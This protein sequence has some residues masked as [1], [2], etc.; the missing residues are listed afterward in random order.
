MSD[1]TAFVDENSGSTYY[2]NAV[3]G[4]TSWEPP[5]GYYDENAAA[6]AVVESPVEEASYPEEEVGYT[7]DPVP[8]PSSPHDSNADE[9]GWLKYTDEA[10]GRPYFYNTLTRQTTWTEPIAFTGE[11]K[12]RQ[13]VEAP[14]SEE[15]E[16]EAIAAVAAANQSEYERHLD[17]NTQT[18]YYL[19]L[20]TGNTQWE[21]PECFK[22][23]QRGHTRTQ[24]SP[25]RHGFTESA[26]YETNLGSVEENTE[27][28]Q[29]TSG[30]GP[31]FLSPTAARVKGGPRASKSYRSMPLALPDSFHK[32]PS[33][34]ADDIRKFQLRGFAND[35]FRTFKRRSGFSR[36][37]IPLDDVIKWQDKPIH[38]SLLTSAKSNNSDAVETFKLIMQF[39]GDAKSKKSEGLL[40]K[41]IVAT[42][43]DKAPLRDE[44]FCQLCKQV[45]ENPTQE[46]TEAGWKLIVLCSAS[47][48]PTRSFE[49]FLT[50]F[51]VKNYNGKGLVDKL[52]PY[53][54]FLLEQTVKSG[55]L[56]PPLTLGTVDNFMVTSVPP[57]LVAFGGTLEYMLK[58]QHERG[59]PAEVPY[60]LSKLTEL[61]TKNGG[62]TTKGMFR[63]AGDKMLT[64]EA[65]KKVIEGEE[66]KCDNPH[67][68]GDLLKIWLRELS[69]TLIPQS[70]YDD[71]LAVADKKDEV[72][73]W[74]KEKLP[75][76]H[77]ATIDYLMC[78]LQELATHS[79]VTS[80]TAENLG[81]VFGPN[82]LT[83]RSNDDPQAMYKNQ[84]KEKNFV[85]N[86]IEAW[87]LPQ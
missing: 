76:A 58:L 63:I 78:W 14:P 31:A 33:P 40:S 20:P 87:P 64:K 38:K 24:S 47:F 48:P 69:D 19:H 37:V 43:V 28:K 6:E 56:T 44:I 21:E 17:E 39:M 35:H 36:K 15:A 29:N 71:C 42:G 70:L 10:S 34:L 22:Q 53:A 60:M 80:M 32:L 41:K 72:V 25:A 26:S 82:I 83:N 50:A 18:Y 61:I 49:S 79:A 81:I 11:A 73:Q 55:P 7:D 12:C 77:L 51:F 59:D 3:T 16:A 65:Q 8:V 84:T 57:Y 27:S 85:K 75:P 66:L 67:L 86:C 5:P 30:G 68:P 23:Q 54:Y 2:H 1:W 46:S 62:A 4:E 74:C 13:S 9:S 45:T 52:A